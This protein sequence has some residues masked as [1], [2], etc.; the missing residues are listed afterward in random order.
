METKKLKMAFAG[1]CGILKTSQLTKLKV[2]SRKINSL[3]K[4]GIKPLTIDKLYTILCIH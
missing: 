2:D 1:N 4:N 3:L